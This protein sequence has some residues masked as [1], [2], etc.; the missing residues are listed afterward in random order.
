MVCVFSLLLSSVAFALPDKVTITPTNWR[1][2]EIEVCYMGADMGNLL[3]LYTKT[4]DEFDF[5]VRQTYEVTAPT[6]CFIS[7]YFENG[8]SIWYYLVQVDYLNNKSIPFILFT[9]F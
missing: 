3:L 5:T 4:Y 8:Q 2:G 9:N 7:P 1:T 6:G